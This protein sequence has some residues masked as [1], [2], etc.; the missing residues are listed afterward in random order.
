MVIP[1]NPCYLDRVKAPAVEFPQVGPMFQNMAPLAGISTPGLSRGPSG[2][3]FGERPLASQSGA[4][5]LCEWV[6]A[7]DPSWILQDGVIRAVDSAIATKWVRLEPFSLEGRG[8]SDFLED[9]E[10]EVPIHWKGGDAPSKVDPLPFLTLGDRHGGFADLAFDYGVF[11][12]VEA[13]DPVF[14][15]GAAER[16]RGGGKRTSSRPTSSRRSSGRPTTTARSTRWPKASPSFWR[17]A[18]P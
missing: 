7:G 2:K 10:G 8:L 11:G 12:K 18:G 9:V 16:R 17:S 6:F 13:H 4:L 15:P 5:N 14:P 1:Q 3:D